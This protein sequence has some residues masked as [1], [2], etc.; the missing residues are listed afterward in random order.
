MWQSSAYAVVCCDGAVWEHLSVDRNPAGLHF[1]NVTGKGSNNL[2]DRLGSARAV[3]L[4]KVTASDSFLCD[5]CR[6]AGTNELAV[7]DGYSAYDPVNPCWC[8]AV[9]ER[10]AQVKDPAQRDQED[11]R[12]HWPEHRQDGS[13]RVPK[14]LEMQP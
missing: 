5:R 13:A 3:A 1:H 6:Q 10:N 7:F 12:N 11:H 8:G 4:L 9:G 14:T 2:R